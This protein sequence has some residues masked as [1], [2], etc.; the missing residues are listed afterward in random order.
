MNQTFETATQSTALVQHLYENLSLLNCSM[1]D[2]IRSI[3]FLRPHTIDDPMKK[4]SPQYGTTENEVPYCCFEDSAFENHQDLVWTQRHLI[5]NSFQPLRMNDDDKDRWRTLG[6]LEEIPCEMIVEHLF[7]L[8][9]QAK[10]VDTKSQDEFWEDNLRRYLRILYVK[11]LEHKDELPR[12]NLDKKAIVL[13][14]R[15]LVRPEHVVIENLSNNMEI[16]PYLNKLPLELG[17]HS[18]F[19]AAVGAAQMPS[20]LVYQRVLAD[21]MTSTKNKMT[22]QSISAALKAYRGLIKELNNHTEPCNPDEQLYLPGRDNKLHVSSDLYYVDKPSLVR[23]LPEEFNKHLLAE[24]QMHLTQM[25][26]ENIFEQLDVLPVSS[27]LHEIV[28]DLTESEEQEHPVIL[29]LQGEELGEGLLRLLGNIEPTNIDDHQQLIQKVQD[30]KVT[31]CKYLHTVLRHR[32]KELQGTKEKKDIFAQ[33]VSGS[34]HLYIDENCSQNHYFYREL[35]SCLAGCLHESID[36]LLLMQVLEANEHEIH[37]VL[38]ENNV[39]RLPG[40]TALH[41]EMGSFVPLAYH[42]YLHQP[43]R[44]CKRKEVVAIETHDPLKEGLPGSASYVYCEFIQ[45]LPDQEDEVY[46]GPKQGNL[47]IRKEFVFAFQE[48]F[49]NLQEYMESSKIISMEETMSQNELLRLYMHFQMDD[50]SQQKIEQL[51]KNLPNVFPE[52]TLSLI[53]QRAE[54]YREQRRNFEEQHKAIIV[55]DESKSG[56]WLPKYTDPNPQPGESVRWLR[57]A[58]FDLQAAKS[59]QSQE[60]FEWSCVQAY[61]VS[62]K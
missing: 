41:C 38:D 21:I 53:Q 30:A 58:A 23:R 25:R 26:L 62:T 13:I 56:Y 3:K 28:T 47:K 29:K 45:H 2:R 31:I 20:A 11:L 40:Q 9:L 46:A 22:D 5:P 18:G 44:L 33:N 43:I 4:L 10:Q 17:E 51:E 27:K 19:F 54:R 15:H 1:G 61:H 52:N 35:A 57:Q 39:M 50:A 32:D 60:S 37:R 49:P 48:Y 12:F 36:R 16:P 24:H 59:A 34:L 14:D 55:Q 7:Q 6:V 8:C 42:C